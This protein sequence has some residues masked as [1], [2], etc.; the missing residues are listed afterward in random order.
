MDSDI[1]KVFKYFDK[2][3]SGYLDVAELGDALRCLGLSPSKSQIDE[4]MQKADQN[5]D[6]K[7]TLNEFTRMYHEIKVDANVTIEDLIKEFKEFDRDNSGTISLNELDEILCS[8]GE[9]LSKDE[10]RE[11]LNDFDKNRDGKVSIV[12]LAAGLLAR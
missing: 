12:E 10:V 7:L 1:D 11:L 5:S 9:P 4:L 8:Q 6:R 3:S 2:D